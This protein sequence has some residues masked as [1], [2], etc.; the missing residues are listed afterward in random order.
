[1]TESP[2]TAVADAE[3]TSEA[4]DGIL[5]KSEAQAKIEIKE[6]LEERYD[7]YCREEES[8]IQ[9]VGNTRVSNNRKARCRYRLND[10][11]I[12]I[13]PALRALLNNG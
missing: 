5:G 11:R 9:T 4:E 1:M 13:I 3:P 10:L 12:R 7:R 2:S 8:L 6:K